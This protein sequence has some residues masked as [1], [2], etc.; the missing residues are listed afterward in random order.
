M[1]NLTADTKDFIK[2][3][4][5]WNERIEVYPYITEYNQNE[6]QF[7]VFLS[8]LGKGTGNMVVHVN[9]NVPDKE[10]A[11][12]VIFIVNSY[13][14]I[15][16]YAANDL[17]KIK[18]RPVTFLNTTIDSIYNYLNRSQDDYPQ[19]EIELFERMAEEMLEG[20]SRLK[21]IYRLLEKFHNE[22]TK[23]RKKLTVTDF[24]Y[25][26]D[27]FLE[28]QEI[29]FRQG[30]IQWLNLKTVPVIISSLERHSS[31]KK[32]INFLWKFADEKKRKIL[33]ESMDTLIESYIGDVYS[34]P[35]SEEG[36]KEFRRLKVLEGE[37]MYKEKII[38]IIRN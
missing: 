10:L 14:N 15:M 27:L 37:V 17:M 35:L 1:T 13:N 4:K 33:K 21:E 26:Y 7:I 6:Y 8:L 30:M 25:A 20:Q 31:D 34:I 29:L 28:S 36:I 19:K 5:K 12:K 2:N 18:E 32:L 24:Q 9:G 16:L 3:Q 38:P 22:I 11:I 23:I